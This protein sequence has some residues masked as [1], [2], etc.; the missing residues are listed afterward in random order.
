ME[1]R[2]L[3]EIIWRDDLYPRFKPSPQKIQEYAENIEY[4]SAGELG[5]AVMVDGRTIGLIY[6]GEFRCVEEFWLS[7]FRKHLSMFPKPP[8][9][10]TESQFRDELAEKLQATGW[11]VETEVYTSQGRVDI[12]ARRGDEVQLIETKMSSKSNDC[13]HALGQLLFYSKFFPGAMLWLATPELPD[14]TIQS[15]LNSYG[16]HCYGS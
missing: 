10:P 13:S 1:T 5:T 14:L 16:V 9:I 15:M 6:G 4:E 3:D 12:V 11:A 2:R 8:A 7:V